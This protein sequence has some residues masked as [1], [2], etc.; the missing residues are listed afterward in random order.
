MKLE[1]L[2]DEDRTLVVVALQSLHRERVTSWNAAVTACSLAGKPSPSA[3]TFGLDDVTHA[4]R[5]IGA[6]PQR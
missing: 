6:A 2:K 4:L 1:D 5:R 3:E